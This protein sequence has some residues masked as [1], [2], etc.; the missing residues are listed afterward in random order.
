MF[1]FRFSGRR[2][3]ARFGVVLEEIPLGSLHDNN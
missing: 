2:L 1:I 3:V